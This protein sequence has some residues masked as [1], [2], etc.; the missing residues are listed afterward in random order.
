MDWYQKGF[1]P[2]SNLYIPLFFSDFISQQ[3]LDIYALI[4]SYKTSNSSWEMSFSLAV[5]RYTESR[6]KADVLSIKIL[7]CKK[8]KSRF[9]EKA[10]LA[11]LHNF[12]QNRWRY[13]ALKSGPLRKSAKRY[14]KAGEFLSQG[15]FS[16]ETRRLIS[17][18]AALCN[19]LARES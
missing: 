13:S 6:K 4:A 15:M 3:N 1:L 11:E 10:N 8:C 12:S 5:E 2:V 7:C 18:T 17:S 19:P 9:L 14:R 16:A